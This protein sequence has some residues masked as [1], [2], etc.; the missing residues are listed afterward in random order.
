MAW[1][2][3]QWMRD[4]FPGG[5]KIYAEYHLLPRREL[6]IVAGA[7]LDSALAELLAKRLNGP[8]SEIHSFLGV[9]GD[10]RAPCGSLGARI[11][12]ALLTTIISESDAIILRTIKGI[13]NQFAHEVRADYN[14]SSVL[15]LITKL[16][17]QFL[18]QSNSLIA[19]GHLG[20][21]TH[22]LNVIKPL[23]P[24]TPEAGAGLLLAVFATYQA[25]LHRI[26]ERVQPMP[27]LEL[28]PRA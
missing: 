3:E 27:S 15:P 22:S 23:L 24:T 5:D 19:D 10:G 2:T 28:L 9:N 26:Y 20:G 4:V 16:H 21:P 6:A 17:D 7:V 13:R 12:L 11:Q 1:K 18:K 14:S 8:E 25:Y